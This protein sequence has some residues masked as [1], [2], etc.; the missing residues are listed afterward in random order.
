MVESLARF[1]GIIGLD[2][3]P[4]ETFGELI[5]YLLIVFLGFGLLSGVFSMFRYVATWL[6]T[7][8]SRL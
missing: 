1:L 6:T 2:M 3:A 4:P 7:G 5:P 8:R